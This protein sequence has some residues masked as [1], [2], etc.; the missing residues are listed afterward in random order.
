MNVFRMLLDILTEVQNQD[1]ARRQKQAAGRTPEPLEDW[2]D[3]L[4]GGPSRPTKVSESMPQPQQTKKAVSDHS[5]FELMR[6]LPDV[7]TAPVVPNRKFQ[8]P[9]KDPLEQL[10]MAQVILGPCRAQQPFSG[11]RRR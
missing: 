7:D 8:L 2:L 6:D 4:P 3:S 11:P 1:V 9:G 5:R 10:M